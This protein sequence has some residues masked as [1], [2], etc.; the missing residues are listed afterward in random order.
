MSQALV[1]VAVDVRRGRV[2]G[3][4]RAN[5]INKLVIP[6]IRFV[7][8][9]DTPGGG[10]VSIQQVIP[11]LEPLEPTYSTNGP[12]VDFFTGFGESD[13]WTMA[14][15]YRHPRRGLLPARSIIEGVTAEWEPDESNPKE[16]QTCNHVFRGVI[17]FEF[18]LEGR[19][20]W[21]IDA[22]ER[23]IRRN[24]VDLFAAVRRAL[25]A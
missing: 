15:A 17:H 14:G 2:S 25:G 23:V 18:H 20:L 22:D 19:E 16:M 12:D 7:N 5:I 21:Y 3:T 1:L 8:V 24:G 10:V 13:V 4:S 11:R 9:E 6:P